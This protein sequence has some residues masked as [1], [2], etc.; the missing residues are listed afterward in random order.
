MDE[1]DSEL[2]DLASE[3][4]G[5]DDVGLGLDVDLQYVSPQLGHF[6]RLSPLDGNNPWSRNFEVF[7]S[8]STTTTDTTTTTTTLTT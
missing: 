5:K 4:S 8:S 3:I 1:F 7:S 6:N 2:E